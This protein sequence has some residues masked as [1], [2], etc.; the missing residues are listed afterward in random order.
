MTTNPLH[1]LKVIARSAVAFVWLYEG[2]VPKILAV[3]PFQIEMVRH[4]GWWWGSPETTLHWLG[5]AMIIA[6]FILFSGWLERLA[7]AVATLSV[8]VLMV[9]VITTHPAALYDPFGGL[10]KDACLF[11]CSLIVW[12]LSSLTASA[13][14]Q[15]CA[16]KSGCSSSALASSNS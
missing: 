2:L 7:Q 11:A 10:A 8:L 4:S 1:Q 16:A 9:L 14:N 15:E 12:Q 5:V 13:L 3:S 6:S